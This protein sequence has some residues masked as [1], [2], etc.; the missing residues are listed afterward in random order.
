MKGIRR[1]YPDAPVVAVA[2]LILDKGRLL[3]VKRK[4]EPSR[5]LWSAPGG[6][7]ELAENV[8]DAVKRE[9]NEET[10]LRVE[11]DRILTVL[12]HII[13]NKD[14][15]VRFHY[16][17]IYF[18]A[19]ALGGRLMASTDAQEVKWI[20]LDE[21]ENLP[22]SEAFRGFVEDAKRRGWLNKQ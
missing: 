5:G 17:I 7:V 15:R 19:R 10:G 13:K 21:V 8:E 16:V 3:L 22:A 20:P 6:V 1:E 2:A 4:N 9:V 11:V 12:N 18:L 14:D